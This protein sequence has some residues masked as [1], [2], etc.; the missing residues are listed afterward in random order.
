MLK[1]PPPVRGAAQLLA[2]AA[3]DARHEGFGAH[4]LEGVEDIGKQQR[5]VD[6]REHL[7]D[8][9][10]RHR[11][12]VDLHLRANQERVENRGEGEAQDQCVERVAGEDA[13]DAWRV[14]R[15]RGLDTEHDPKQHDAQGHALRTADQAERSRGGGRVWSEEVGDRA[16]MKG[17]KKAEKDD[18]HDRHG[19]QREA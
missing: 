18:Q 6:Q 10:A 19:H 7:G 12:V 15:R 1:A 17:I 4:D 16:E 13:D 11:D 8:G 2:G 3:H 14:A 9:D 5:E